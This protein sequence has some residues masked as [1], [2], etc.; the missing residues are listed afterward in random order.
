MT[1]TQRGTS[2]QA[3]LAGWCARRYAW[4]LAEWAAGVSWAGGGAAGDVG[5][6]ED[7]EAVV[8]GADAATSLA[9]AVAVTT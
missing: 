3:G 9:R 6:A 2:A 1:A 7:E 4:M 8:A 5:A